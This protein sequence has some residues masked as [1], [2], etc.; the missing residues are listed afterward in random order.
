[1]VVIRARDRPALSPGSDCPGSRR[2]V[3]VQSEGQMETH[4]FQPLGS[5]VT[6][7]PRAQG[8]CAPSQPQGLGAQLR[9]LPSPTLSRTARPLPRCSPSMAPVSQA[10]GHNGQSIAKGP[11]ELAT[12]IPFRCSLPPPPKGRGAARPTV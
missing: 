11:G 3:S 12:H 7:G 4:L 1:M 8:P 6:P 2:L 9:D 10:T 5:P